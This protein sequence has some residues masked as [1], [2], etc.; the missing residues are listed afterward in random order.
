VAAAAP[1]VRVVA[2]LFGP[3]PE[4]SAVGLARVALDEMYAEPAREFVEARGGAVRL[5]TLARVVVDES[6]AVAGVATP[7]GVVA[8]RQ[9]ISTVPWHA[10]AR[11]WDGD[12]PAAVASIARAAAGMAS[13]PI[14]T[15][16]LWF[17]GPVM[18]EPFVGLVDAPVHW[19]FNKAAIV[20]EHT[21]HLAVVTSGA[22]DLA[23]ADN[24][25]VARLTAAQVERVLPRARGRT[26]L[27]AVVVRE[28]RATFSLAPGGPPRPGAETPLPGFVMAG[29]WT[30]TGLPATIEGAVLSGHR[31]A[32]L[33]MTVA[34]GT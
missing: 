12:P 22:D 29:D 16:N 2:Q 3:A 6:G 21:T 23:A 27:R 20:G 17:D 31:A 18:D 26:L 19:I 10:F 9:V 5:K 14:V 25:M 7:G 13:S 33:V 30:D 4:D 1:F 34:H 24:D 15:V 11:L 28:Q 32:D 8:C